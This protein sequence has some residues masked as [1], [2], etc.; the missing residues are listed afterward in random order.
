MDTLKYKQ[1]ILPAPS[2]VVIELDDYQPKGCRQLFYECQGVWEDCKKCLLST[3]YPKTERSGWL[4][5]NSKSRVL[6]REAGLD[7]KEFY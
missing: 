7:L 3:T 5:G 2:E 4:K 1:Y 6:F